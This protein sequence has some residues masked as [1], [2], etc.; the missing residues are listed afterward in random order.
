MT[1][2]DIITDFEA[3]WPP[4][5]MRERRAIAQRNA[6]VRWL[7]SKITE[8]LEEKAKMIEGEKQM[9]VK[10]MERAPLANDF[11]AALDLAAQIIRQ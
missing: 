1:T 9:W 6:Q 10:G 3:N 8:L 5:A 7:Q 2:K 4:I 11:N